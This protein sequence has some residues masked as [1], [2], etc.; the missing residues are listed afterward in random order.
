MNFRELV[1]TVDTDKC[2]LS[3][4]APR[5]LKGQYNPER[6]HMWVSLHNGPPGEE[7][8]M[9]YSPH[10]RF[11]KGDEEPY[12]KLQRMYGRKSKWIKN[13]IKKF[14]DVYESILKN[15]FIENVSVLETPLVENKYNNGWEIY[16]GHHR[17][18]I[19]L[20]LGMNVIPCEIIRR[21]QNGRLLQIL[22]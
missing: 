19:A 5:K 10:Y 16:E 18:A 9:K 6:F 3:V 13:K 17:V 15:G 11:L 14:R 21:K 4:I 20:V 12:W 7:F 8:N 1:R 22:G 2:Y